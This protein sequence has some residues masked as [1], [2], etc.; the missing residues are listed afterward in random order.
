[1][2]L[3]LFMSIVYFLSFWLI[4][5][6]TCCLNNHELTCFAYYFSWFTILISYD[7]KRRKM[8]L[9]VETLIFTKKLFLVIRVTSSNDREKVVVWKLFLVHENL[10]V[11]IDHKRPDQQT[12]SVSWD[13]LPFPV[14]YEIDFRRCQLSIVGN[15]TF[16]EKLVALK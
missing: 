7:A 11:V 2:E 6:C 14:P 5:S 9:I 15:C 3:S 4:H 8:L 10:V 12:T 13:L 16:Y 1:M